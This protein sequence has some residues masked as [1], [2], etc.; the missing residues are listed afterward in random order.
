[1]LKAVALGLFC[2]VAGQASTLETQ[3]ER[4]YLRSDAL[5]SY[6]LPIGPWA[7]GTM[8][9]RKTEGTVEI[10]AWRMDQPGVTTL[11]LFSALR[12]EALEQGFRVLFECDNAAQG[13]KMS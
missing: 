11:D 1:M 12:A 6:A 2:A 4:T 5:A 8:L 13:R 7:D 3:A 10:S 9:T